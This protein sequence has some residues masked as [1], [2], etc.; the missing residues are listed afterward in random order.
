MALP[1]RRPV[2]AAWVIALVAVLVLTGASAAPGGRLPAASATLSP[3]SAAD[4]MGPAPPAPLV[5]PSSAHPST[6]T[7]LWTNI[8]SGSTDAPPPRVS[9]GMVYDSSDGYVLLFGGERT[10]ALPYVYYN[11][12]WSFVGGE[13]TNQTTGHAPSA[14]FGFFLADDPADHVVVLFGGEQGTHGVLEN[15]TWTYHAGTW[16]N[17]TSGTTPPRAFW[18]SMS[19]DSATGTVLLFGGN[20]GGGPTTEY[21]ND[22]W[23]FHAGLWTELSPA[24]TPPGRD[25]QNQVDDT[26]TG[27]V[28]LFGGLNATEDL[29]DT[30]TYSN[31][32]WSLLVTATGPDARDGPGMAYDAAENAVVMYGGYPA[33]DYYYATWV[34]EAG[35]WTQYDVSPTPAAGTIWGQMT[36]DAADGYVVLLQ[37]NGQYNS[38]WELNF[39]S[40]TTGPL[41]LQ[42]TA[43]PTSGTAPLLVTFT[44]T[45]SGGT[46]PYAYSWVLGDG[47]TSA[48]PNP[49]HTYETASMYT[50]T[51]YVT[52]SASG[53][54][55]K[56]WT[57]VVSG[58]SPPPP[59]SLQASA[60]PTTGTAPLAVAFTATPSGGTTPYAYSWV[61]GD[62]GRSTS[63][64]PSHTY[65]AAASYTA[66]IYVT[67]SASGNVSKSWTIVASS[68][69]LAATI[70]ADP[71]STTVNHTVAF[72][73]NVTGGT[74]PYTFLWEFA[75]HT[76]SSTQDPTHSYGAAGTFDVTLTVNDSA[77]GSVTKS[78]TVTV[79]TSPNS[80]PASSSGPANATAIAAGVVLIIVIVFVVFFWWRRKKK[81]PPP[82][83]PDPAA[84][85]GPPP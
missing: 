65:E 3:M 32:T 84:S 47:N 13:W 29:N 73:T 78:V 60:T 9:A 75:D 21:T 62:G 4:R 81:T 40:N 19:Y 41:S 5:V 74:G 68:A 51:I 67:D 16:T 15:D 6:A 80:P 70:A 18:G 2:G 42:A 34:L 20:E 64:N 72:F 55:S 49:T 38:T 35:V 63:A 7:P 28:V 27:D 66:T 71:T 30:W 44:A 1:P 46:P 8:S 22:T 53:N 76:S 36:Y 17:V 26:A 56:S 43:M 52:D 31:G 61:F 14:R 24:S 83:S 39:T 57:I 85:P 45:P 79:A 37:G 54:V 23:S 11:D 77:G 50:A 33:N 58:A 10:T 12:T 82:G 48:S 69:P 59:L 25:D